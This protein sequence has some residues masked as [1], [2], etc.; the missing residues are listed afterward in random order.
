MIR[1]A[2]DTGVV[3]QLV[4]LLAVVAG[5]VWVTRTRPEWRLVVIGAGLL[6]LGLMG[7]R[8]AH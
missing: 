7:L 5:L 3:V 2:T 6:A 8:A 1:P 4:V